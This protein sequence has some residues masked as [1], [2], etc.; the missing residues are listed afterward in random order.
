MSQ[1]LH[2]RRKVQI[3][4]G[5]VGCFEGC[6]V[7]AA[8]SG[9]TDE[10]GQCVLPL[11]EVL[12]QESASKVAALSIVATATWTVANEERAVTADIPQDEKE[13][14]GSPPSK[15]PYPGHEAVF[16]TAS[17]TRQQDEILL[18]FQSWGEDWEPAAHT[19]F[20]WH[21]MAPERQD[22]KPHECK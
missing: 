13:P 14:S 8:G 17:W 16:M 21:L 4:C 3:S 20:Y 5:P 19:S 2:W 9:E 15:C 22:S 11:S 12:C 10:C 18:H 7:I 1:Y 6:A